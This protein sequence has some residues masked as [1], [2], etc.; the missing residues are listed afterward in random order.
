M[1]RLF[2]SLK[3][4]WIPPLG[5]RSVSAAREDLGRYLEGY[6]NW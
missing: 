5:Y 2:R 4:K 3:T 6:Y 1:E